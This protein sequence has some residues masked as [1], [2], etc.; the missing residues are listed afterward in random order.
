MTKYAATTGTVGQTVTSASVVVTV[1][2]GVFASKGLATVN[3]RGL[4]IIVN[5]QRARTN[6]TI[7]ENANG[8]SA[9]VTTDFEVLI[10]HVVMLK[11][12]NAT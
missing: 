4:V 7:M 1:L 2:V 12:G 6:V 10:A 3:R 11:M 9:N 5:M 8:A